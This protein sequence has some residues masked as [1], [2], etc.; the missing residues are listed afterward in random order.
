M[1]FTNVQ[2]PLNPFSFFFATVRCTPV[3]DGSD[4]IL[5]CT[6]NGAPYAGTVFYAIGEEVT[7]NS[8]SECKPLF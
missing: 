5:D 3:I 2:V 7:I 4:V 1:I 6:V 8:N